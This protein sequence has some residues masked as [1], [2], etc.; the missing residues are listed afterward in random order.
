M[1]RRNVLLGVILFS[2]SYQPAHLFAQRMMQ[3]SWVGAGEWGVPEARLD[4]LILPS[5]NV[6]TA[7][8]LSGDDLSAYD[9]EGNPLTNLLFNSEINSAFGGLALGPSGR[10]YAVGSSFFSPLFPENRVQVFE[11]DGRSVTNFIPFTV[12]FS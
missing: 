1:N 10:V 8:N 6:V 11:P 2:I 3:D 9:S 5:G 4:A 12:F 7:S